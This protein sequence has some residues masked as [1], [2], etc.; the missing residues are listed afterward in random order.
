MAFERDAIEQY[1]ATI[2]AVATFE[3][4]DVM[5]AHW[6]YAWNGISDG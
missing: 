6:T 3:V 5:T 1:S 2:I 4:R